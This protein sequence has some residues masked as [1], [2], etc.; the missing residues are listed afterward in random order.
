MLLPADLSE[1][2]VANGKRNMII[3]APPQ[4]QKQARIMGRETSSLCCDQHPDIPDG[5]AG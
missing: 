2:L 4:E 1:N 5:R 3:I